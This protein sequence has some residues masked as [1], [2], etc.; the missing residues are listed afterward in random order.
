MPQFSKLALDQSQPVRAALANII[1]DVAEVLGSK[2]EGVS[3]AE[4]LRKFW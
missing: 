2:G 4:E 1:G 3:G